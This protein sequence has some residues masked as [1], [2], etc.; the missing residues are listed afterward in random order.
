MG[1]PEQINA[2]LNASLQLLTQLTS[3]YLGTHAWQGGLP[4]LS[5]L[6]R[7]QRLCLD[8]GGP[9]S[10][11]PGQWIGNLREL[12]AGWAC[13]CN[14]TQVLAAA[15]QLE[16]LVVLERTA[17]V[18]LSANRAFFAWAAAHPPLRRLQFSLPRSLPTGLSSAVGRLLNRRPEMRA[19]L[20]EWEEGDRSLAV[21]PFVASFVPP[22]LF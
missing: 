13:L 10:L 16:M 18:K 21:C 14:S 4:A 15:A 19:R 5:A 7:L 22:P 8:E 1:P 3:L 2:Q 17:A 20:A 12:G 9:P 11:P 6:S